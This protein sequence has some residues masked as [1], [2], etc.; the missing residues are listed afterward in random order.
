MV[1]PNVTES[2]LPAWMT[3]AAMGRLTLLVNHVLASEPVAVARLQ[4]HAERSVEFILDGW[5]AIA[6]RPPRL[7]FGITRAGLLDWCGE[8]SSADVACDLAW[9]L[10]ARN[11]ARLLF[12][13]RARA[14]VE[15]RGDPELAADVAWVLDNV[16]WD[17]GD[18]LARVLGPGGAQRVSALAR[19]IADGVK[20][21]VRRGGTTRPSPPSGD[22]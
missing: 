1:V 15:V 17:I 4:P 7:C 2:W 22:R 10:D 13:R 14:A 16:R 5:P 6:P 9:H 21:A 11:P 3:D 19:A 8:R 20:A 12:A 18:D